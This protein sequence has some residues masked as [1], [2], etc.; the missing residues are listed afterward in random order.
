[1]FTPRSHIRW[2]TLASA[3]L[4]ALWASPASSGEPPEKVEAPARPTLAIGSPAPEFKPT[5]W[6]QGE[7]VE[8]FDK[9]KVYLVECWATFSPPCLTAIPRLNLRHLLAVD[10]G[11]IDTGLDQILDDRLQVAKFVNGK[12]GQAA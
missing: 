6:L 11:L 12:G 2:S 10:F 3:L 9:T 1:M 8:A 5:K 4:L 7:P